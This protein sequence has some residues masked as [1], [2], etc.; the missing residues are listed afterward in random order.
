MRVSLREEDPG[1][2]P[3]VVGT[4]SIL[5][6]GKDVTSRCFTADDEK[7]I[8][9]CYKHNSEGK[10]YIDNEKIAEEI[11]YGE[12]EIRFSNKIEDKP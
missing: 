7:G 12:I 2:N 9:M 6:D 11:L 5:V 3:A 1:Y 10:P 8:A 4:C